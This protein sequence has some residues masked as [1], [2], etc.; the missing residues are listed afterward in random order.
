MHPIV[1]DGNN[2]AMRGIQATA[3]ADLKAGIKPTGGVYAFLRSLNAVVND[4]TRET[5][6]VVGPIYIS[7]DCGIP[8]FRLKACPEYKMAR[9]EKR[10]LWSDEDAASILGQMETCRLLTPLMGAKV[11]RYRNREADDVLGAFARVAVDAGHTP[12]V[13]SGDKDLWQTVNF[14]ATVYDLGTRDSIDS[15]TIEEKTGMPSCL[16]PLYKAVLGDP[17]DGILGAKGYGDKRA[18]ELILEADAAGTFEDFLP[19]GRGG[20][21]LS[22]YMDAVIAYVMSKEGHSKR[23]LQLIEDQ[24]R[25][26]KVC[27]AVD[28]YDSFGNLEA[29]RV[30]MTEVPATLSGPQLQFRF[31][32]PQSIHQTSGR[33]SVVLAR[34]YCKP[35]RNI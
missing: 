19:L 30:R 7:F 21:V 26:N 9:K 1:V 10:K 33:R 24:D 35:V 14:G 20:E 28:L 4:I 8:A 6:E 11:L 18:A 16:Y 29:L 12:W 5:R 32:Q 31:T 13:V 17:S 15:V 22:D 34:V 25:L 3:D 2:I 27:I 23:E